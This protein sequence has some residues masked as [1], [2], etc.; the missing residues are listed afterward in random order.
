[1]VMNLFSNTRSDT[2]PF[3]VMEFTNTHD[4]TS[5]VRQLRKGQIVG[6]IVFNN[7]IV[8]TFQI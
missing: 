7:N 6:V 2:M 5:W 4:Y 1:M 3:D 8:V